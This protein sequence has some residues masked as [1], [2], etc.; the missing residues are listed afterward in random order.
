MDDIRAIVVDLRNEFQEESQQQ[1]A[2]RDF[3]WWCY[4]Y[5]H[6]MYLAKT[7]RQRARATA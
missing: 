5:F 1:H 4:D 7:E 3:L 2:V 6:G